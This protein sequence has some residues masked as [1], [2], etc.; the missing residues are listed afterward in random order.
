MTGRARRRAPALA[1]V[2]LGALLL[3]GCSSD[4]G[5]AAEGPD[6]RTPGASSAPPDPRPSSTSAGQPTAG[7]PSASGA[8]TPPL[9]PV[10]AATSLPALMREKVR[11]G[12]IRRTERLAST[13]AWTSWAVTY[14]VNG[15]TVSGELLVPTGRGPFPAVVLNHGYIDP[16]IYTLGRGLSR[17]Q[18]WLASNGFVVL[19][20]DY[21]GHAASDPVG[22][23]GRETR[24]V[25]TRDAVAAVRAL[26]REPAVD[27]DRLAML[28]RSMGGVVTQ[29]ALVVEPGLVDAAVLFASVSSRFEDNLRRFTEPNRPDGAAAFYRRFGRPGQS[30]AF[31]RG[32]SARSYFDRI[33]APVLIHH[34]TLDET[35][36]IRWSRETRRSMR[37]QGV[38]ATLATYADGHAFGPAFE[39]S[40]RR[41][42]RF[43]RR[44]LG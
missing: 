9:P 36:P 17:E 21:R 4:P 37:R 16:E 6:S 40:M 12:R 18:E 22:D 39:E 19:H 10:P 31:Y 25:Y 24:L 15:S 29:N 28:G 3:P 1:A 41:T 5:P 33:T 42:V 20:T 2:A 11:A 43:L 27:R 14:P 13:A 7:Q 38:Q 23:L 34:G 35:C 8:E 32:L 26:R 44:E 30:P